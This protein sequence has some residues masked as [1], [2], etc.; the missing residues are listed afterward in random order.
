MEPVQAYQTNLQLS[1]FIVL[2][3][4]HISS[5]WCDQILV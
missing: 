5:D 1:F 3:F 2:N 4:T